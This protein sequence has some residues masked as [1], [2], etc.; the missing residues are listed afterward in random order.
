MITR[1]SVDPA[2]QLTLDKNDGP[3]ACPPGGRLSSDPGEVH[4]ERGGQAVD[5][6]SEPT[7]VTSRRRRREQHPDGACATAAER[8]VNAVIAVDL[9]LA[10][11][12]GGSDD[13][14]SE[15]V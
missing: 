12:H 5:W 15:P 3:L 6:H 11:D 13:Q 8:L 7:R 14:G 1:V 10:G 4:A 9:E 2:L